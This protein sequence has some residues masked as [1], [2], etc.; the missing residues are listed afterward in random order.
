V[1]TNNKP[2]VEINLVSISFLFVGLGYIISKK[3]FASVKAGQMNLVG[4]EAIV[5]GIVFTIISIISLI[6]YIKDVMAYTNSKYIVIIII[7]QYVLM[8]LMSVLF[9]I[10]SSKIISNIIILII[11]AGTAI[12]LVIINKNIAKYK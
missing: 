8:I 2:S 5:A 10:I 1:K 7:F 9:A 11:I 3:A 6:K 4:I 12:Y